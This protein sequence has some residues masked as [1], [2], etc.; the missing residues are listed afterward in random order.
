MSGCA[1]P[2]CG[3]TRSTLPGVSRPQAGTDLEKIL[4]DGNWHKADALS[5]L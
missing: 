1:I 3:T 2:L 5:V 4:Y